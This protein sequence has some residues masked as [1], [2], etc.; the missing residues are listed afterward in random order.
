MGMVVVRD[1]SFLNI[2]VSALIL[3]C[4]AAVLLLF[5]ELSDVL[6]V[7]LSELVPV[8]RHIDIQLLDLGEDLRELVLSFGFWDH[9][10][11]FSCGFL[12]A[13]DQIFSLFDVFWEVAFLEFLYLLVKCKL[14]RLV[15]L[16]WVE[17]VI[18]VDIEVGQFGQ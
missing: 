14:H 5:H 11:T 16:R 17:G 1:H 9:Y 10:F 6:E 7:V 15:A 2:Q 3:A 4:A 13:F 12:Q 18:N 8:H